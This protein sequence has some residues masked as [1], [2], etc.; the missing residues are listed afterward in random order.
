M[1]KT[2]KQLM[3][4]Q[5]EAARSLPTQVKKAFWS[6]MLKGKTLGEAAKIAGIDDT[7]IAAALTIQSHKELIVPKTLDE[8]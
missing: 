5:N 2:A 7:S 4:E 1:F 8:I 3:A 6:E